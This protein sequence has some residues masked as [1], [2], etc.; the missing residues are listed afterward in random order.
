MV[1]APFH[2]DKG[3]QPGSLQFHPLPLTTKKQRK[4]LSKIAV[5][6]AGWPVNDRRSGPRL[7]EGYRMVVGQAP[8]R[9]GGRAGA[10]VVVSG[11]ILRSHDPGVWCQKSLKETAAGSRAGTPR[12]QSS[13]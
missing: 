11:S 1:V 5:G 7:G 6:T 9:L 2:K 8:C 13:P 4:P 10:S 12:T 3:E